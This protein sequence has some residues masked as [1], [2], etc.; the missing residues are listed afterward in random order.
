MLFSELTLYNVIAC[1]GSP[2]LISSIMFGSRPF[3]F[4]IE[5]D[6]AEEPWVLDV[7]LEKI[8]EKLVPL[9]SLTGDLSP[10]I[11]YA[12]SEGPTIFVLFSILDELFSNLTSE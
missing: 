2:M 9:L 8:K 5:S 4:I 10:S 1:E 3:A 11:L 7:P 12:C 6:V